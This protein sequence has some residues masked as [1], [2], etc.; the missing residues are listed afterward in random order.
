MSTE[1][2][3]G[4]TSVSF[5]NEIANLE[6]LKAELLPKIEQY[7]NIV[8][9]AE[10]IQTAKEDRASLNKLKTAIDEQ[11]IIIKKKCMEPYKKLEDECKEITN[12]ILETVQAI[13]EK[14]KPFEDE[15]RESK[16]LKL[17]VAFCKTTHHSWVDFNSVLPE[18]WAN[19]SESVEKLT[20]EINKAVNE[21]NKEY[22]EI[23]NLYQGSPLLIAIAYH[24]RQ[25][26]NKADTLAYA[27][28][29]ERQLKDP[30]NYEISHGNQSNVIIRVEPPKGDTG[31]NNR[32]LEG[33]FKVSC[34]KWKLKALANFM[35]SNNIKF[36][37]VN[38]DK[39]GE[40]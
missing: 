11:R 21:I 27:V 1:L 13:D 12:P 2:Q 22:A 6:T 8:I 7:K 36:A 10:N 16:L 17:K 19:K 5:P 23:I 9:T 20:T 18:N 33:V 26:R 37:V 28:E 34:E 38:S 40:E 30:E 24:Y 25:C 3:L 32:L 29:L 4:Y 15:Y 14:L 31:E 35:K 39:N